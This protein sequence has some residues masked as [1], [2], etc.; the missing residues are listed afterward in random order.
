MYHISNYPDYWIHIWKKIK[1]LKT[2]QDAS[3]WR[4]S[5]NYGDVLG[6]SE[7]WSNAE[8]R[9]KGEIWT[10]TSVKYKLILI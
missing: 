6:F 3:V 7:V 10:L 5:R 8:F 1:L 2:E 4:A 9:K